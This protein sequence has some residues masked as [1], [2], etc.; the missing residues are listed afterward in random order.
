MLKGGH[1]NKVTVRWGSTVLLIYYLLMHAAGQGTFDIWG[2]PLWHFPAVLEVYL[3]LRLAS[4]PVSYH[5]EF[6]SS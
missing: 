3:R 1:N 4:C 5:V 2:H 6:I